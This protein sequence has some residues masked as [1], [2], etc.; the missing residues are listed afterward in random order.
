MRLLH[1]AVASRPA[2]VVGVAASV[3]VALGTAVPRGLHCWLQLGPTSEPSRRH[4]D[5]HWS[6]LSDRGLLPGLHDPWSPLLSWVR[7]PVVKLP[8][9]QAPLLL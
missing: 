2:V 6:Q 8:W 1:T 3:L 4:Q 7:S 5:P 9:A